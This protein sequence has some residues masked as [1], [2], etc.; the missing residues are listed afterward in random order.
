MGHDHC[1]E[2]NH[3]HSHGGHNHSHGHSHEHDDG[4]NHNHGDNHSHEGP[5]DAMDDKAKLKVLL[6]HWIKHNTEHQQSLVEWSDKARALG[7]A[8]LAAALEKSAE[9]IGASV[10]TLRDAKG[11]FD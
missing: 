1:H 10:N 2:H 9:E 3:E 11:L 4:H 8:A 7:L 5:T 6:D